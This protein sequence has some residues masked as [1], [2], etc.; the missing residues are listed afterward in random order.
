MRPPNPPTLGGTFSPR[1]GGLGAIFGYTGF[2]QCFDLG[3]RRGRIM[4]M[5]KPVLFSIR[6][7]LDIDVFCSLAVELDRWAG[8]GLQRRAKC[9][10]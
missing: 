5:D 8:N 2:E 4:K 9:K 1:I 7:C 6:G 3:I 10:S